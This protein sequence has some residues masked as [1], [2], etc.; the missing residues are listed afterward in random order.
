MKSLRDG[1]MSHDVIY[2]LMYSPTKA[3][4]ESLDDQIIEIKTSQL[5]WS[6][7]GKEFIY[8]WGYPGPDYNI[9]TLQTYGRGWAFTKNEIIEAWKE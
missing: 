1:V 5:R 9:Y 2:S 4:G 7:D 3:S 6:R 8:V